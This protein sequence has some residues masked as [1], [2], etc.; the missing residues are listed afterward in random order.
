MH[1]GMTL[2]LPICS[3]FAIF[4]PEQIAWSM[5][6]ILRKQKLLHLGMLL[7][8][9]TFSVGAV[10]QTKKPM[11]M[12]QISASV[13]S[14][15]YGDTIS[16]EKFEGKIY[17]VVEDPPSFPGGHSGILPWVRKNI[18]YPPGYVDSGIHRRVVVCFV[19]E[20]D[21]SLSNIEVVRGVDPKL[22]EEAVRLVKAMP[23]WKPGKQNGKEV[24]VKY[25]Q[26]ITF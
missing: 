24:R 2:V 10:A 21:G 18:Q 17:D 20:P 13:K 4:A 7:V 6:I 25:N 3:F 12:E 16:K 11:R 26:P 8:A 19:V 9:L 23:K 22:D 15:N 1:A 5:N 14:P